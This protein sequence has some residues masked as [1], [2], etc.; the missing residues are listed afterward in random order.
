LVAE[1]TEE[2]ILGL[3]DCLAEEMEWDGYEYRDIPDDTPDDLFLDK[4]MEYPLSELTKEAHRIFSE[5]GVL[6]IPVNINNRLSAYRGKFHYP[7]GVRGDRREHWTDFEKKSAK[8]HLR[9]ELAGFMT[10]G[11]TRRAVLRTLYHEIA[12][13]LEW[14]YH[15]D[16]SRHGPEFHEFNDALGGS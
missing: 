7:R 15:G 5:W 2:D 6:P 1:G 16:C 9:I 3:I 11:R 14:I 13:Y 8:R 10:K 12:H 4:K